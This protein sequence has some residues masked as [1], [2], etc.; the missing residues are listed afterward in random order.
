MIFN[1]MTCA[2]AHADQP[3]ETKVRS[4]QNILDVLAQRQ[5][6]DE[7]IKPKCRRVKG[8]AG[9]QIRVA[10]PDKTPAPQRAR[11]AL[12]PLPSFNP[13]PSTSMRP[14]GLERGVFKRAYHSSSSLSEALQ[15]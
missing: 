2:L 13:F 7:R 6:G 15:I 5:L 1:A 10:N 12:F 4:G 8:A 14:F 3:R 9:P 11:P